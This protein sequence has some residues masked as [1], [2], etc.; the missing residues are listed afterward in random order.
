MAD[1]VPPGRVD[2]PDVLGAYIR[3]QLSPGVVQQ[4]QQELQEG[5]LKLQ[6]LRLALQNQQMY[7][8]I[9]R[10]G[11]AGQQPAR[12]PSA[13]V[14]TGP[15]GQPA[16]TT[17]GQDN[18]TGVS[19]LSAGTLS[20]LAI[21]RGDDPL[22]TAEGVQAYQ[23]K[24]R[25]LQA[26]GPM[27]L[28]ET[29]SSSPNADAIIKNNPTLQQQ[30]I[31]IAPKLGLDPF[32][33]LTP[34]NARA[35]AVYGYNQL[36]G[37]A[38]LPPKAMPDQLQTVTG[39]GGFKYKVDP[40]TG[41]PTAIPGETTPIEQARLGIEQQR[42]DMAKK[43]SEGFSGQKGELL[44]AL[45]EQGVSLPAGL[46]SKEQQMATLQGL[47]DR[48]PGMSP[49]EI[50]SQVKSGKIDL[51]GQMKET[52]VAGGIA[53]K[54]RYAEN[55]LT[56]SIP[57][58]LDAS[59]AV[60][61]GSFMPLNRLLQTANTAISDPDLLNLKIK[62][63]SVLNAYDMLAARGGT[64][65]GKREAQHALL[66]SAQSPEAFEAGL[67]AFQQEAAVARQAAADSMKS[68]PSPKQVSAHPPDVQTLLDKYK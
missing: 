25:Q 62:T 35:A 30:W 13:G 8:Q 47:I 63:Q 7:Q 18:Q 24:Q 59:K 51:A 48:N 66:T 65:V 32:K 58:A 12:S 19:G 15:Q 55:E 2:A 36:A 11:L 33:D 53:G 34:E 26:Q 20:S 44:A 21:L 37:G 56:Q 16:I 52:T 61:R 22:K 10:Q 1:F 41:K 67:K 27:A 4:Q 54:V 46:R 3:G 17:Q 49:D 64:D 31:Q 39:Q 60:P 29:V 57:L 68:G 42:L 5:G 40:L 9:A 6:Q 38:G 28:A 45:A 50:A 43:I 14:Q 23:I